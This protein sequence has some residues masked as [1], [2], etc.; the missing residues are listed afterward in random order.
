LIAFFTTEGSYVRPFPEGGV[1][2]N[3]LDM[4]NNINESFQDNKLK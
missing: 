2:E 4:K 3:A 1:V